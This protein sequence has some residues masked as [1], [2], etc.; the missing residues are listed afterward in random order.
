MGTYERRQWQGTR[1][2]YHTRERPVTTPFCTIGPRPI[3]A[4][5]TVLYRSLD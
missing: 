4:A 2:L 5:G 1:E 3:Q